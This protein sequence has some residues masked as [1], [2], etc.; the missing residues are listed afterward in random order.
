MISVGFVLTFLFHSKRI[1]RI[2]FSSI[3]ESH[4]YD[5]FKYFLWLTSFISFWEK[6]LLFI[7]FK[8]WE[9]ICGFSIVHF[10]AGLLLL[11]F[12]W[13]KWFFATPST[14]RG[15]LNQ[16]HPW[17][18]KWSFHFVISFLLK[19]HELCAYNLSNVISLR[20]FY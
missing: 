1:R 17:I 12:L 9:K 10:E 6:L 18:I 4:F 3:C 11:F 2:Y 8:D 20:L 13:G 14:L 16:I 15:D 7:N 5:L 19:C